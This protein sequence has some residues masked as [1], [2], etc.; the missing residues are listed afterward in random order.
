MTTNPSL[1]TCT[2]YGNSGSSAGTNLLE[3]FDGIQSFSDDFECTFLHEADG[4]ADL[5]S[6]LTEG[7]RLKIDIA[8]KRFLNLSRALSRDSNYKKF[9]NGKF[10]DLSVEYINSIIDFKWNGNWHRAYEVDGIS[11][12]ENLRMRFAKE[13][14]LKEVQKKKYDLY[15][16]DHWAPEY[17]PFIDEYYAQCIRDPI[18]HERFI[19]QTRLYTSSLLREKDP[20]G[21]FRYLLIDQAIPAYNVAKYASYFERAKTIIIDRDPRDLYACNKAEWGS[22]YIPTQ[23]VETFIEWFRASRKPREYDLPKKDQVLFQ[24]FDALVYDYDSSVMK[25]ISFL[26]LQKSDHTNP[27]T[28]FIPEK[29]RT[30]TQLYKR[31]PRLSVDIDRI[32]EELE[33]YCYP[34]TNRQAIT[35]KEVDNDFVFIEDIL[36]SVDIA[37]KNPS[38]TKKIKASRLSLLFCM[39]RSVHYFRKILEKKG[40]NRCKML[41]KACLFLPLAPFQ[42]FYFSIRLFHPRR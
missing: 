11:A 31:Y 14:Y 15:E 30:N 19:K 23:N 13:I 27:Q 17:K 16:A 20:K 35:I 41:L 9:F 2:G 39:T 28:H 22:R 18:Y 8:V 38:L 1:V 6:A 32:E 25:I 36:Q 3:E 34:H 26:N 10:Y 42:M 33:E 37:Q 24:S 12:N 4:V 29:S 40:T 7:H 5:E 21:T